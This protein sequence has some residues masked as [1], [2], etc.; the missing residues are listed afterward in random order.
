M[1]IVLT[2]DNPIIL[3][4]QPFTLQVTMTDC[5]STLMWASA[6]IAGKIKSLKTET[7]TILKQ[8]VHDALGADE[9][10]PFF[11]HVMSGSRLIASN[12]S[13]PKT[14]L[15]TINTNG[16]PPT[17]NGVSISISY[18]LRVATQIAGTPLSYISVPLRFVGH[19][20]SYVI[21]EKCQDEAF[22]DIK[23]F[24]ANSVPAPFALVSTYKYPEDSFKII[25]HQIEFQDQKVVTLTMALEVQ[26]GQLLTGLFT[27]NK[28]SSITPKKVSISLI[29]KEIFSK[30]GEIFDSIVISNNV[31]LQYIV[32][33][34][35]SIQIPFSASPD[36]ST[37][38]FAVSHEL[39]LNF[40]WN[41]GTFQW[42]APFKVFPP[43]LTLSTSRSPITGSIQ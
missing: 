8:I 10:A 6:Q 34:R 21:L 4:G 19:P 26:V 11:G 38:I 27:I 16:I 39:V 13:T 24:L 29:R 20:K 9:N 12:F 14:F 17:Y 36:F 25:D 43:E 37:N 7:E 42:S 5:P 30:T 18:E 22:F 28:N 2:P 3:I 1:K 31:D 40:S 35:F 15:L 23:S 41:Q 33:R 32:S